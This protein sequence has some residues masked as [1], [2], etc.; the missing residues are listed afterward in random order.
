MNTTIRMVPYQ[1]KTLIAAA[2]AS[3]L[4]VSCA[5]TPVKT[6]GAA[7]ARA[8]L[9]R[10][11][12][13][14]QLADRAPAAIKEA[15][16]AVQAAEQPQ[17]DSETGKYLVYMADRKIDIASA[18]AET[19]LAEDQR[20]ALTQQRDAARLDARTREVDAANGK[21][22]NA[23]AVIAE[24]RI[25][26]DAD[27]DQ[28]EAARAAA[29]GAIAQQQVAAVA[30]Q[31]QV[32]A[33]R[34][35]TADAVAQQQRAADANR[36]QVAAAQA[37]AADA[38]L[39]SADLQRQ[40]DVLHARPS[41]RGMVLTLGDNTLF[42]SGKAELKQGATSSLNRLVAFLNSYP[43]RNV[44][45][46]G[47]TDNVGGQDYNQGLSQRRADSV[48]AYLSGQGIDSNRL[49][50]TGM[51]ESNPV[52]GNDSASGRQQ[53]RRVDVIIVNPPLALR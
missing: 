17:P 15:E 12:S 47:Y 32:D 49:N 7:E 39:Q 41:D 43:S 14:P 38:A 45:I 13:D 52:A 50:A 4:L 10:L 23:R 40:L 19:S 21:L 27:R 9:T 8:K 35:E 22:D 34:A 3:L 37:A 26:V 46:E 24:Q 11:Q 48:K 29:A 53:N 16:L 31:S 5:A 28:M 36:D 33:A 18:R 42:T 30:N 51:G 25:T 6:D 44:T 2:V 20:A 1:A